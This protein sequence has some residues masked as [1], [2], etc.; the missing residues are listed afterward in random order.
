MGGGMS[1]RSGV[2]RPYYDRY[3]GPSYQQR[4]GGGLGMGGAPYG[5][6]EYL[7]SVCPSGGYQPPTQQC[8]P[9]IPCMPLQKPVMQPCLPQPYPVPCPV[10]QPVPCPIPQPYP[11][12]CPV[13]QPC[14]A[15]LPCLPYTPSYSRLNYG[16]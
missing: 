4:V 15:P 5:C 10:P 12:P 8:V 7:V 11:V 16:C 3:F 2:G 13:P 9:F 6:N 14:P 1:Q